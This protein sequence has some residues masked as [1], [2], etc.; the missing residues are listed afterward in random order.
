M[1]HQVLTGR[2][3]GIPS[4]WKEACRTEKFQV[5]QGYLRELYTMAPWHSI[6]RFYELDCSSRVESNYV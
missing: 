3:D 2:G 4:P 1:W 5:S 6:Y